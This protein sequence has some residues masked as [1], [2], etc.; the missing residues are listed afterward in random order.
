MAIKFEDNF[1]T[2][3]ENLFCLEINTL[4]S[5]SIIGRKMPLPEHALIDIAASYD[6]RLTQLGSPGEADGSIAA[7]WNAFDRLRTR[8]SDLHERGAVLTEIDRLMLCRIR[9]NS[10]QIKGVFKSLE[11]RRP[12]KLGDFTRQ[13]VIDKNIHIELLPD[14]ILIVRKVWEIGTERIIYQTVIQ[15]DGDVVTRLAPDYVLGEKAFLD[16]HQL[17]VNQSVNFWRTLV[18]ILGSF[19]EGVAGFLRGS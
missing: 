15:L 4:L 8:A 12:D 13:A 19:V 3:A 10:D 14:E 11:Q 16:V 18:G 5:A 6:E 7:G 9:D 17:G 1:R 2:I